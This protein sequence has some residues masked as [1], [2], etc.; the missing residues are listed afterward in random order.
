[1]EDHAE[2]APGIFRARYSNGE[3][4]VCNYADK[5]FTYRGHTIAAKGYELFKKQ[6]A[7]AQK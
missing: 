5:P 4:M 2:I 7:L 6:R 1:M 3:E